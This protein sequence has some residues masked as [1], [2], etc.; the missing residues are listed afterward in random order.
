MDAINQPLLDVRDLSV[1]FGKTLAVDHVSF[2]IKRGQCVALVGESG[3]GK[4]VSALSILKL[5]PYPAASHP[6]GTIHF[7]G[8]ELLQR[9]RTRDARDPR[10]RHLDHLPG[11]DDLAQSAPHHRGADRRDPVSCISGIGGSMARA[12]TL[13]LLTQVGIPDPETR[14]AEL[15]APAVRRPAPARD[16]RDGARQRA[17]SADRRRADHC[18]R[19][20]RAGADPGAAR[21]YPAAARHE[22]AVHHPR[23]RHRPPHRRHRLRHEQR[24]DRRAGTG[25]AGLHRAKASLHARSA[26]RRTEARSGAAAAERAGG[27]EGR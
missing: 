24:Q 5:L 10:Q 11:A 26:R 22:P 20:H 7:K 19:R 18:A 16:D 15:S 2:S 27:D 12:R 17:G 3:S 13:E 1:A 23:S 6:S 25:R 14:L 9:R 8:R 21:R 4:S